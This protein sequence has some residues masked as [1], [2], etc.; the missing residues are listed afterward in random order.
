M[1]RG[2]TPY[3][4]IDNADIYSYV[5]NGYRLPQPTYCPPLLYKSAMHPC[6]DSDPSQRPSFTQLAYDIRHILHQ[7]EAE[8]QQ[9]AHQQ[10]NSSADD[11]DTTIVERYPGDKRIKRLSTTSMSSSTSTGGQY[12]TTPHRQSENIQLLFDRDGDD[13]DSYAVAVNSSADVFSTTRL[14]PKYTETSITEDA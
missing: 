11:D 6:W 5:K 10:Q 3:T 8:Q 1:S 2:K 13:D 9:Q 7:L 14:L 12:I 4:G